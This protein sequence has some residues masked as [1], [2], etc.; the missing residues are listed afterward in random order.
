MIP[1]PPNRAIRFL[2]WFCR[3]DYLEE[4]E[5]DLVEIFEIQSE[6]SPGKAKRKFTWNVI[7]Y[8]RPAFIKSFKSSYQTN[9]RAMFRHNFII[10]FRNFKRYKTSFFINLIGLSTGLACA[11]LIYTWAMDEI[12]M[13]SFHEH[14]DRIFQLMENQQH[15]GSIRKTNSTPWLLAESL[16]EEMPEVEFASVVTPF[17]WFNPF[18]LTAGEK[19]I[20]ATGMYTGKDFF[21]MFSY[22]LTYGNP[23]EV[24]ADKNYVVISEEVAR[25]LF[26]TLDNVIGKSIEFQHEREFLISGVFENVPANSSTQF[27]MVLSVDLLKDSQ[28]DSFSWGNSGPFT[29]VMLKEGSSSAAFTE[30]IAD[31]ISTKAE[32]TH[33]ILSMDRYNETYL[34]SRI[35]YVRLFSIIAGFILIIACINFMNLA[36]AR[37][38]R[39]MKEVGIK[40]AVGA[41]RWSLVFQYLTESTLI[42]C[43]ALICAFLIAYLCTPQFNQITGKNLTLQLDYN[44]VISILGVALFTGFVA[45]S[46]PALYLSGFKPISILK[47]K[48]NGSAGELWVRKG[49]VIFQFALSV[50]FVMS[51]VVIYKQIE[52]AQTRNIGY[53]RDNIVYFEIEGKIKSNLETFLSE[54]REVPG[55]Q[56]ASSAGQSMV[57]GGN[58]SPIEWEGKDLE[59]RIPFAIRPANYD[60]P[61]MMELQFVE[62]RSYSRNYNDSMNVIFNLASIEAMGMEDPVGKS[63][64]LGD[65]TCGIIGVV[66][67]FHYESFRSKVAPLFFIFAPE[68]TEKVMVRFD[69]DK[70]HE[71][72]K[73][74]EDFYSEYNPGFAFDFRFVDQD[75]QRQYE[76]EQRVGTLSR[77]FGGLAILI[78]CLGLLGLAAFTAEKRTKEIGIRKVMG[79]S[80]FRIIRLLSG[81]FTKM[82]LIAI[83][84]ALPLSY[85][86]ANKWLEEYAYKI[87]LEWWYFAGAGL[88]ALTIAWFTVGLQ[89]VKAARVNPVDCLR[90]E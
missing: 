67:N 35:E 45:G 77:Y 44:M 86:I 34:A 40:K 81:D 68:H 20:R 49:M 63:I 87:E 70:V 33:R 76:S 69:G 43:M 8:F 24:F 17:F 72:L 3:E 25:G 65:L 85:I 16:S 38:S 42:S 10:S 56:Y 79:S 7:K 26:G 37:A 55:V 2:R 74:V 50:I 51:V 59:V 19:N 84:I 82:V 52:Y 27:D 14:G 88:F 31:Y 47:G 61:E 23:S 12:S 64:K 29:F 41:N 18:T 28:P 57:G 60:L 71:T 66:E 1:S 21:N 13:D 75:Y 30:K 36:T 4:I 46:Y 54:L 15:T 39:R 6:E 90:D 9:A 48:I 58:T 73:L 5:G 53:S 11:L 78:S 89:T 80:E 83:S 32:D 22:K 62:G